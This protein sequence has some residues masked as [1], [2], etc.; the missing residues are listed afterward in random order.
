MVS[1]CRSR[2][3][4]AQRQLR[5]R[6]RRAGLHRELLPFFLEAPQALLAPS[7][8]RPRPRRS[9]RPGTTLAGLGQ[10]PLAE[11]VAGARERNAACAWRHFSLPG[12]RLPPMPTSSSGRRRRCSASASA[13]LRGQRP[14]PLP[15][16]A[17]SARTPPAA[18]TPRDRGDE[19][20][21]GQP[22]RRRERRPALGQS[23]LLGDR[24]KAVR[25][26]AGYAAGRRVA[27]ARSATQRRRDRPRRQCMGRIYPASTAWRSSPPRGDPLPLL[28]ALDDVEPSPPGARGR[29]ARLPL[30]ERVGLH[31]SSWWRSAACWRT[32]AERCARCAATSSRADM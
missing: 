16:C 28:D 22:V 21:A 25:T 11:L 3:A 29:A 20:R 23:L 5:D 19:P 18:S 9:A 30:D 24:R 6:P 32:S 1:A 13:R 12:L 15:R 4:K 7:F 31:R 26:A 17:R 27:G 14:D 10:D 8:D 2:Q